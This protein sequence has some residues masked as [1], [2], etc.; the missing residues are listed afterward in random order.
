MTTTRTVP[1]PGT[2]LSS[3]VHLPDDAHGVVV[4]VQDGGWRHR[5][6]EVATITGA[7]HERGLGTVVADLHPHADHAARF[8]VTHVVD[9][10]L[11]TLDWI[12]D[13]AGGRPVGV[14]AEGIGAAAALT[15]AAQRPAAVAAVVCVAGHT[16]LAR[17]PLELVAVPVLLLVGDD[18]PEVA[19]L[20]RRVAGG[21]AGR[22]EVRELGGD[23]RGADEVA[24]AA[25]GWFGE[26][27]PAG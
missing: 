23:G 14:L 16:E 27:L 1:I 19:E 24:A 17:E 11:A 25:A 20:N 15:A 5:G 6:T 18:R 8:E 2:D 3:D 21:I 13:E 22:V 9:G 12:A 4:L 26:A 10:L 7:L